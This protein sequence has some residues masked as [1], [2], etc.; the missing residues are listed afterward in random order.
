[1]CKCKIVGNEFLRAR[2]VIEGGK[3]KAERNKIESTWGER[4]DEIFR[5]M[6]RK[7]S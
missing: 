4:S 7:S 6:R 2:K 1:M 5:K 3:I